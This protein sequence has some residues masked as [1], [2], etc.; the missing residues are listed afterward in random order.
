M[1]FHSMGLSG[2]MT[3][4]YF[5]IPLHL[6]LDQWFPKLFTAPYPF[7]HSISS[8]VPPRYFFM[9]VTVA[10]PPPAAHIFGLEHLNL[11]NCQGR[12]LTAA[13]TPPSP[14]AH[15]P[16]FHEVLQP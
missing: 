12:S 8:Y 4:I 2:E 5:Q 11:L 3:F 6:L 10:T 14:R 9:F 15:I 1:D 16:R 13:A 7:R